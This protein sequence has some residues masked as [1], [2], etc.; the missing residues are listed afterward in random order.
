MALNASIKEVNFHVGDTVEVSQK[1]KE[2]NKTRTQIFR[3]LVIAIRGHGENKSFTVRRIA[4]GGIGVERIWSLYSP[5][6]SK[7][8]VVKKG[9]ARRAKLY[10]LR[11]R[12]GREAIRVKKVDKKKVS[13]EKE[14][15]IRSEEKKSRKAGRKSSSKT[16]SK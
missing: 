9:K 12:T 3:S 13:K 15:E 8:K 5:W 1:V 2:G 4:A 11:K 10:Y 7:I 6:I 14:E 16:P